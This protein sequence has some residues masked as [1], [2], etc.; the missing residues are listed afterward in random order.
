MGVSSVP[1]EKA[2]PLLEL[3]QRPPRLRVSFMRILQGECAGSV[4][5]AMHDLVVVKGGNT[6]RLG[7]QTGSVREARMIAAPEASKAFFPEGLDLGEVPTVLD[8]QFLGA[9]DY[10]SVTTARGVEHRYIGLW[11][12][13]KMWT[14]RSFSVGAEPSKRQPPKLLLT[15]RTPIR[16]IA[17]F[18]SVDTNSGQIWLV[19]QDSA[20]A[21]VNLAIQW[22]H[23][24]PRDD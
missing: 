4:V 19:Q 17:F 15:A 11:S 1:I 24:S 16:G 12:D 20:G 3:S 23:D 10:M 18:P 7:R 21:T 13:G 22:S 9:D 8:S 2:S 14:V 5:N 6:Y